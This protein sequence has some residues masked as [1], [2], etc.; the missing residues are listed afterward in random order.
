SIVT[1]SAGPMAPFAAT[2]GPSRTAAHMSPSSPA[3][4][5]AVGRVDEDPGLLPRAVTSVQPKWA[6]SHPT[7]ARAAIAATRAKLVLRRTIFMVRSSR[8]RRL[9]NAA[10]L[11]PGSSFR[12]RAMRSTMRPKVVGAQAKFN[13]R[14]GMNGCG[15]LR[16]PAAIHHEA[17]AVD[18]RSLRRCEE[19][20]GGGDV[21]HRAAYP[22]RNERAHLVVVHR[23]A[24]IA[25][26]RNPG[27]EDGLRVRAQDRRNRSRTDAV[28][29]YAASAVGDGHL[30]CEAHHSVLGGDV[31]C[32]AAGAVQ[33]GDRSDVDDAA[34]AARQHVAQR[35][36]ADKKD[37]GEIDIDHLAPDRLVHL[38]DVEVPI[39]DAGVV[40]QHFNGPKVCN[41]GAHG[42]I[43]LR[44]QADVGAIG[45]RP[46]DLRRSLARAFVIQID[47]RD[48]EAALAQ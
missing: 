28:H 45:A 6:S 4:L 20:D 34:A 27:T 1:F 24:A 19:A 43:D 17:V 32:A 2:T 44:A 12:S 46:R 21:L 47:R 39:E 10:V 18:I 22:D 33:A 35:A 30:A 9:R 7:S 36:L 5:A 8:C 38:L 23:Y 25:H 40:H 3:F 31:R 16:S 48:R 29:P 11:L 14:M 42:R 26:V 15:L 13:G 37:A 41:R